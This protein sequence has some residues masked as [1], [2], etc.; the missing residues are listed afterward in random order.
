MLNLASSKNVLLAILALTISNVSAG[1]TDKEVTFGV[2]HGDGVIADVLYYRNGSWEEINR[3][4]A[5]SISAWYRVLG[6][7]KTPPIARP[8]GVR[9]MGPEG[10]CNG[11][12]WAIQ[13]DAASSN[14]AKNESLVWVSNRPQDF[15]WHPFENVAFVLTSPDDARRSRAKEVPA[16]LEHLAQRIKKRWFELEWSL[17]SK[18]VSQES[19]TT[20]RNQ[21]VDSQYLHFGI[22][23]ATWLRNKVTLLQF[24]AMK[25]FQSPLIPE[26]L[27]YDGANLFID[28][29]AW[30]V[31]YPDGKITWLSESMNLMTSGDND[32]EDY[33]S[34][35]PL[36]LL[37]LDNRFYLVT[38]S[39]DQM[40]K[41][42]TLKKEVFEFVGGNLVSR[43]R[44]LG[45]C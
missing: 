24:N 4:K 8:T 14:P 12:D 10:D 1:T 32:V 25:I 17:L 35:R 26:R 39:D 9:E 34:I 18:A 30:A 13:S 23:R 44:Y 7:H 42:V 21:M 40:G 37:E 3:H 27:L 31:I 11:I 41:G 16:A 28:Y 29:S 15:T 6:D 20:L 2:L 36:A 38:Q 22:E 33:K 5:L 43:R 45:A 19:K